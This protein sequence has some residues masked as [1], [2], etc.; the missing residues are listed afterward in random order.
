[1]DQKLRTLL[2]K[3][4]KKQS[5]TSR[6]VD[7]LTTPLTDFM[8]SVGPKDNSDT[9]YMNAEEK[10]GL[11]SSLGGFIS[12]MAE[13]EK[14]ELQEGIDFLDQKMIQSIS[15]LDYDVQKRFETFEKKFDSVE[16]RIQTLEKKYPV[17]SRID[18][19]QARDRFKET[20]EKL[21]KTSIALKDGASMFGIAGARLASSAI[22]NPYVMGGLGLGAATL[23]GMYSR[24]SAKE[25][26]EKDFQ[27]LMKLPPEER[28]HLMMKRMRKAGVGYQKEDQ[29]EENNI[30]VVDY[31]II[32]ENSITL[33]AKK[34]FRIKAKK[35]VL[36]AD[37]IVFD[38]KDL[39][40][41][42]RKDIFN[43]QRAQSVQQPQAIQQS[44]PNTYQPQSPTSF[45]AA[46]KIEKGGSTDSFKGSYQGRNQDSQKID[47]SQETKKETKDPSIAI[48]S[49]QVTGLPDAAKEE[50]SLDKKGIFPGT[51]SQ[52]SEDQKTSSL[53][54]INP[55]QLRFLRAI[56]ST[57]SSWNRNE[58]YSERYNQSANNSNV[59]KIG[60]E[61]KDY[62]YFQNN[63]QQ[64]KEAV[65]KYGMDPEVAKHLN[66]GGAGGK[67]TPEQQTAAM[68]EYLSKRWP[69]LY[70][71]VKTGDPAAIE[72]AKN[73]MKGT[74]FGL[75]DHWDKPETKA[76]LAGRTLPGMISEATK[77]EKGAGV[78]G[79]NAGPYINL[80]KAPSNSIID[81]ELRKGN[82]E[83]HFDPDED[84][85]KKALD[86]VKS[87]GGT[88][89]A[90]NKGFGNEGFRGSNDGPVE[91][92]SGEGLDYLSKKSKEHAK[93]GYS[94]MQIDNLHKARSVKELK[95]IFDAVDPSLKIVPNGNPKLLADLLKEHPEYKDR[96]QYALFENASKF[97]K[98]DRD[99]ASL[100]SKRVRSYGIEFGK[101]TQAATPEE[102]RDLRDRYGF[103]GV[104]HYGHG[105]GEDG[106]SGGISGRENLKYYGEKSKSS[107]TLK[108][109]P[110]TERALPG[111]D[112]SKN[113]SAI[114]DR[115]GTLVNKSRSIDG[116]RRGK[117]D[118]NWSLSN[119]A[120]KEFGA[121]TPNPELTSLRTQS[122]KNYSVRSNIAPQTEAFVTALE[123]RG[124][125]IKDIGGF[126]YRQKNGGGSGLSTHATGTTIDINPKENWIHTGKTDF[127]ENAEKLAWLYRRSWGGRFNDSMHFEVMS[128]ELHA[129]RLQQLVEEGFITPE[130]A[131]YAYENGM[132]PNGW[133]KG[134]SDKVQ[135][136]SYL[137]SH[138]KNIVQKEDIAEK[139][140][141]R[142]IYKDQ[143]GKQ[144]TLNSLF[145]E[146]DSQ[147]Y[148]EWL[149][150]YKPD[151]VAGIKVDD[152]SKNE[153]K[154]DENSP[155]I[156]NSAVATAEG[157][158]PKKESTEKQEVS[159]PKSEQKYQVAEARTDNSSNKVESTKHDPEKEDSSP[160]SDGHGSGSKA[161]AMEYDP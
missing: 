113:S 108:F 50:N 21:L 57:E 132:P 90:Y 70:E 157:L 10:K 160:G 16:K 35:I 97:G 152:S 141:L 25:K 136:P 101:G 44:Q 85:S 115:F 139:V 158:V 95:S 91:L 4:F 62:G 2:R 12:R 120:Q 47:Q 143:T 127:S 123:N 94:A 42:N 48:P 112:I 118:F 138:L 159:E 137:E 20:R 124:Y 19:N 37:T 153:V 26:N 111:T 134:K 45:G 84:G 33:E 22:S 67:S 103:A 155:A 148:K 66:G 119:E 106:K 114:G 82:R 131:K 77:I 41:P 122:G 55:H 76:V 23:L 71:R 87:R 98:E 9:L 83:F 1:M 5:I 14:K 156:M 3:R 56:G 54:H 150:N 24:E 28:N 107:E 75:Q 69:Q 100:I 64:V 29:K 116:Y 15:I 93:D 146:K 13:S 129:K 142:E 104:Y 151:S 99:A 52:S 59:R 78:L 51:S 81:D 17:G 80:N 147:S 89:I 161:D 144:S 96:M 8:K 86:Y 92:S 18:Y 79:S 102:A 27:D 130:I 31:S 133:D 46:T 36:S 117:D 43:Q 32:A 110:D 39:Q 88:A 11:M 73:A 109:N 126:S 74:W 125:K 40:M 149:K 128:K 135:I 53:D 105:E 121:I 7:S 145:G 49:A 34:E 63:S 140:N 68:H 72:A 38:T 60:N 65:T 58:A 154:K 6:A 61:G 30:K